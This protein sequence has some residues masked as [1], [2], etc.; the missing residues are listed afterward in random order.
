DVDLAEHLDL[1]VAEGVI[2]IDDNI[3]EQAAGEVEG[4]GDALRR[5]VADVR[6]GTGRGQQVDTAGVL[7]QG[8]FEHDAIHPRRV[9]AQVRLG[10][11]RLEVEQRGQVAGGELE[12][13]QQR[14]LVFLGQYGGDVDRQ[15]A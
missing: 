4:L 7:D 1:L 8:A 10:V 11:G 6:E 2:E 13:E 9:L 12:V 5:D 3:G 15:R 14:T